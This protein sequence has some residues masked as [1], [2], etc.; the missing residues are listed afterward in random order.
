[1]KDMLKIIY[2]NCMREIDLDRQCMRTARQSDANYIIHRALPEYLKDK[3][4]YAMENICDYVFSSG[5]LDNFTYT[6]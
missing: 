1:M 4:K 5:L 2:D 6:V 3:R